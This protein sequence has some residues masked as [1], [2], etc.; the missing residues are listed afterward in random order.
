MKR[1]AITPRDNWEKRVEEHGLVYHHHALGDL[2][3]NE[4]AY[5]SFTMN[6]VDT[7]EKA[8][9]DLHHMCLKAVDHIITKK[10]YAGFKIPFKVL[11][12]LEWSW[13][14]EETS[15]YGR[16]DL[17]YK[18]GFPPKL[19]EYNADT[20]TTLLEASVIQ[21]FWLQDRFPQNDQFNSIHERLI[22]R[23][24]HI[25]KHLDGAYLYFA[26]SPDTS[27]EDRMTTTYLQETAEEA[28]ISTVS[29]QMGQI[30]WDSQNTRFVDINDKPI[31]SIFKLYPWEWLFEEEFFDHLVKVYKSS[32]WI[33]PL[34]KV[35]LSNKTILAKLWEMFPFHE[36]LLECYR[37]DSFQGVVWTPE[38][39]VKKPVYSREGCNVSIFQKDKLTCSEG[40]YESTDCVYQAYTELPVFDD[41]HPVI[42]SWVIDGESAGIGIRETNKL[43]T[44]NLSMFVPH[45]ID[46]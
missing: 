16:F 14:H 24:K 22:D 32:Q 17:A 18:E 25:K 23:W 29:T 27:G 35:L 10:D 12:L 2:Y 42:G 13:K 39:Y 9:N 41:M 38:Q 28:D 34:W 5:Y 33:E 26:Y 44:D 20:P 36:N 21:W 19:L 30:G 15:V 6:E 37:S 40:P 43:I 8:T 11:D 4:S 46:G 3:W 31:V 45:L 1:I 7:L